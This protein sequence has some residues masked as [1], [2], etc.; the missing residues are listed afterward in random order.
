MDSFSEQ[1][2]N[3]VYSLFDTMLAENVEYTYRGTFTS[4]ISETILSLAERNLDMSDIATKI[5]KRVYFIMVEGLQNITRHQTP[6]SMQGEVNYPAL[7]VIQ[8]KE[9]GYYIT[10]GNIIAEEDIGILTEQIEKIN[11]LERKELKEYSLEVLRNG[12]IS[13]KGGAGLGLIQIAR[14]SGN[15]LYYSFK[16]LKKDLNFFYL[17]TRINYG[18]AESSESENIQS[19]ENLTKLHEHIDSQKIILNFIGTFNQETLINLLSII[20]K[21]LHGTV[22]LKVKVFNLMVEMLQN[23]V[24]HADN[25]VLNKEKGKH[26]IFFIN[27][28]KEH[29]IFNSGNFIR[30]TK[31]KRFED[32]L[33]KISDLDESKL[34]DFYNETLFNFESNT[35]SHTG[36]GLIDIRMKSG[37]DFKFSF[38]QVDEKFSFFALK[39]RVNKKISSMIP[40]L[41][42]KESDTPEII[43]N[44]DKG[45]FSF[46]GRSIPENAVSFYQPV[47]EWLNDYSESPLKNTD[48]HFNFDYFNTASAKQLAKIM[49]AI[50]SISKHDSVTVKWHYNYGDTDMYADGMRYRE[51][52]DINI[53]MIEE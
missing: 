7:F 42:Q 38:T 34:N 30:N 52:L 1:K 44:A 53:E 50:E 25:Y 20:E 48:I 10:T 6:K 40:F 28:D 18:T 29:L 49:L 39:I 13:T 22:V 12:E 37:N 9:N 15:K 36:L 35:N 11:S 45:I 16:K 4:A 47:I 31:I 46:F 3:S 43:L 51:L 24:K 41:V 19:L 33:K 8:K 32:R 2:S 23:I 26:G 21:Q 27:E 17:H 14:K 5:R